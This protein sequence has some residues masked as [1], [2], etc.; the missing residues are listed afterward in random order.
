MEMKKVLITGSSGYI[1]SHLTK[2]LH[3]QGYAVYGI[4]ISPPKYVGT[5]GLV[6]V[7]IEL[8]IRNKL[9]AY[10]DHVDCIVH[11]AA[12]VQVGESSI[13]P[14]IYYSTN[15]VGTMKAMGISHDNFILASTGCA[16]QCASP[17][18]ISKLAAEQIVQE[19]EKTYY[20]IFRFYNVIGTS[21]FAPT[22]PDGL[23]SQLINAKETGQF[24]IYGTDYNTRDGTAIRDYV[25]VDEI[26]NAILKAIEEPANKVENLGHG[27]GYTVREIVEQFKQSN[28]CSFEVLSGPRRAGDL[29]S[30]ILDNPSIYMK[31]LY[32]L[33]QLLAV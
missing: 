3:E 32:E 29:E 5:T 20:T 7:S 8:D 15:I 2:L 33:N 23:M 4:D 13:H 22:N 18:A 9:S 14:S 16:P 6:P 24:T 27:T 21:G 31:K 26:C 12:L 1:G 11:L 10:Y 28:N 25:H 19:L 30:S 17:Y